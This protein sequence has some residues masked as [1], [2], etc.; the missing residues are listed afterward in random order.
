MM[1][2]ETFSTPIW[3]PFSQSSI[4]FLNKYEYDLI[5]QLKKDNPERSF[6]ELSPK[7]R[8]S[9]WRLYQFNE[10]QIKEMYY[11]F[12]AH[13]WYSL[14]NLHQFFIDQKGQDE[15]Q[16]LYRTP[17]TYLYNN[18]F[19]YFQS[20]ANHNW[21]ESEDNFLI[22]IS[23]FTDHDLNFSM[24]ALCLP[25]RTGKQ[26][27]EHYKVLLKRGAIEEI[28]KEE[29]KNRL[30]YL[31]HSYF[32]PDVE[33]KLAK[34]FR[35]FFRNGLRITKTLLK[36]TATEFYCC[37]RILA[38]RATFQHFLEHNFPIYTENNKFT[39]EFIQ[40]AQKLKTEIETN[41][42]GSKNFTNDI[43][44][45]YSIPKPI[46]GETWQATFL[47][48]HSLS[49]RAAH[50][51]RRGMID[52]TYVS[53]YINQVAHAINDYGWEFVYNMDETSV[54]TNNC[55]KRT[56]APKGSQKVIVD[57]KVNDKETFTM[58]GTIN[59][60][61]CFKPIILSK[62]KDEQIAKAKFQLGK[63]AEVWVTNTQNSW[64][65]EEIMIR[66]LRYIRDNIAGKNP[67]ALVLDVYPAHRTKNVIQEA[68]NLNIELI[69]VPANGTGEFQPLDR[70]I[71]G[72][73]KSKLRAA[74]NRSEIF[75]GPNRWHLIGTQLIKTM[76]EIEES[77]LESAWNIDQLDKM[78]HLIA[79]KS[80]DSNDFIIHEYNE[81]FF[82]GDNY[83]EE[84]EENEDINDEE[85]DF[86]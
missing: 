69:Y 20:R 4:P 29:K 66:Y 6:T 33:N 44:R 58:I 31:S 59:R 38:E 55:S 82:N 45:K 50:F 13:N 42:D 21:T 36:T 26:I 10:E 46:F 61:K 71:F 18:C 24:L 40:F 86:M 60:Y 80:R 43:I 78:I 32:L 77:H 28:Q 56:L 25:G 48:K 67:C 72:I 84:E 5:H 16:Q 30:R 39:T 81:D 34:E 12:Q 19:P 14:P 51:S 79:T 7:I 27:R 8:H 74:A 85:E 37:P 63:D 57:K 52:P 75:S 62:G 15:L 3:T 64:T 41:E 17:Q 76:K 73:V 49:W 53:I 47:K 68:G 83:T 23:K 70:T 22:S 65:N 2:V 1:L 35:R 11:D 9:I 54:R